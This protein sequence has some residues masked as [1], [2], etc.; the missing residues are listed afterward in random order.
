MR[1]P[2]MTSS[3]MKNHTDSLGIVHKSYDDYLA[4]ASGDRAYEI[5][6]DGKWKRVFCDWKDWIKDGL[7]KEEE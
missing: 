6:R 4:N 5:A 2:Q 7:Y 3:N 1:C